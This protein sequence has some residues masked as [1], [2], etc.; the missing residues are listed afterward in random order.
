MGSTGR[1]VDTPLCKLRDTLREHGGD[2]AKTEDIVRGIRVNLGI[3]RLPPRVMFGE[4]IEVKGCA[5]GAKITI[6]WCV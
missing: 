3:G 4:L 6:R 1:V 2:R 5:P